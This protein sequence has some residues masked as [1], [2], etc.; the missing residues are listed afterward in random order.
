MSRLRHPV[1]SLKEPFG[2]AGLTVAILALVLAMVGGAY[3][4]SALTGKQKKEVEKIA[5][6]YAGKPG[7]PG[8]NG[9]NG[10]N[11]A[12]GAK[13][14]AGAPG[15]NGTNGTNGQSVAVT[16]E[17][18]GVNCIEGGNKLVSVSGTSYVCNGEEGANG[19]NGTNGANA[20]FEY[21][22][23][24][25]T[26]GDPTSKKLGLNNATSGSATEVRISE[27]DNEGAG[28]NIAAAIAKWVSGPGASGTLMIR[29][30]S[31]QSTYAEYSISANKDEG[32]FD[33]LTVKHIASNGTFANNDPITV[34]YFA[35]AASVLPAGATETGA[36]AL[37]APA[38]GTYVVPISFPIRLKE[39]LEPEAGLTQLQGEP[40]FA[41]H[42]P[43]SGGAPKAD[44][45][46]LCVYNKAGGSPAGSLPAGVTFKKFS[47]TGGTS[48]TAGL[49]GTVMYF[50]TTG[51]VFT[52]GSWAVGGF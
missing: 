13:G 39:E 34:Q 52:F 11:G 49:A 9:V 17:A 8:A 23:N 19:T 50:E 15:A 42:C 24:S 35:S 29:K 48:E 22:F 18:P 25:A 40:G 51:P 10:S 21:L 38:A 3:A 7:A 1:R 28:T 46:H 33:A 4:A 32:T 26:S 20:T 30:V 6:K 2:K 16:S 5:K 41:T 44:S 43:G 31:T 14:E 37:N 45:E 12:P 27:T 47:E 36:W